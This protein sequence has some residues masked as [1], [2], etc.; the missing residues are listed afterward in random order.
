MKLD[1]SKCKS[2][3]DVEKVFQEHKEDFK[4]IRKLKKELEG[5]E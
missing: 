1:F 5:R 3:E 2:K 4:V